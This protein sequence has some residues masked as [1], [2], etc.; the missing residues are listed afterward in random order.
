MDSNCQCEV[1][2][3]FSSPWKPG[4]YVVKAVQINSPKCSFF[5]VAWWYDFTNFITVKQI[6]SNMLCF[7][8]KWVTHW[9][10]K[11]WV[12]TF[13]NLSPKIKCFFTQIFLHFG[14]FYFY[15]RQVCQKRLANWTAIND[16]LTLNR[17]TRNTRHGF[18][19]WK[20][21][22]L[23]WNSCS[24]LTINFSNPQLCGL[25]LPLCETPWF[26]FRWRETD[27]MFLTMCVFE[28]F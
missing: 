25:Q 10:F 13:R 5:M 18:N 16:T 20:W 14:Q 23:A 12:F 15:S 2:V 21:S 6:Y 4:Q 8:Q 27:R 1:F 19:S 11:F 28:K 22:N 7:A 17:F 9:Y 24:S 3:W 26:S